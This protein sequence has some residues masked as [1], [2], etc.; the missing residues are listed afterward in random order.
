MFSVH[1][2]CP[3]I[4]T[5][6]ASHTSC[7][8]CIECPGGTLF[9]VSE[10]INKQL[11]Y[12]A[13]ITIIDGQN[14]ESIANHSNNDYNP[15]VYNPCL[16]M[17]IANDIGIDITFTVNISSFIDWFPSI[18]RKWSEYG[19]EYMFDGAQRWNIHNLRVEEYTVDN[20]NRY[21]LVRCSQSDGDV[22]CTQCYFKK[23]TNALPDRPLFEIKGSFHFSETALSEITTNSSIISANQPKGHGLHVRR[24][25][26]IL[27]CNISNITAYS[28]LFE[29][30]VRDVECTIFSKC[31]VETFYH[32]YS[33]PKTNPFL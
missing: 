20:N 30:G 15:T 33:V 18:C 10:L 23:I 19:N 5:R 14:E 22:V 21:G 4:S 3:S 26:M 31:G 6:S 27:D 24:D 29:I 1:T 13:S 12:S 11:A 9:H 16:P 28:H 25:F 8:L 32:S 2:F 7:C 17:T